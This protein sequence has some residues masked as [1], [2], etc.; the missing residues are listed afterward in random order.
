MDNV[1]IRIS[2][3]VVHAAG[4]PGKTL[5]KRTYF[6]AGTYNFHEIRDE[7]RNSSDEVVSQALA[8]LRRAQEIAQAEQAEQ[9]AL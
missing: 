1:E 5:A 4:Y 6:Q 9:A 7:V 2:V 3:E 8:D